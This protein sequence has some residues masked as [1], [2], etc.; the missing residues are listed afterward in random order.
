[1]FSAFQQFVVSATTSIS[2]QKLSF[3]SRTFLFF[4][5]N[6][7]VRKSFVRRLSSCWSSNQTSMS[8]LPSASVLQEALL[9]YQIQMFLSTVFLIFFYFFRIFFFRATSRSLFWEKVSYLHNKCS[10]QMPQ[11]P[12]TAS[13]FTYINMIFLDFCCPSIFIFQTSPLDSCQGII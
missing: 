2:Y 4:F 10:I 11:H 8:V 13:F 5:L 6:L 1:M 3:L 7:S 12:G 9:L